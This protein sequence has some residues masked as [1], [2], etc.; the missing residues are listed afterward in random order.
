MQRQ[1]ANYGR[2]VIARCEGEDDGNPD[3]PAKR[4]KRILALD[5]AGLDAKADGEPIYD[6]SRDGRPTTEGGRQM[7]TKFE[8]LDEPYLC[9]YGA[10][11]DDGI[12]VEVVRCYEGEWAYS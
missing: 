2:R 7:N 12:R 11:R 10:Y 6:R 4:I 9:G 5:G 8:R 3:N 1:Y